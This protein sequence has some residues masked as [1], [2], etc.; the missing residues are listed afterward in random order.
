V[1]CRERWCVAHRNCC[2]L[3]MEFVE[4][5]AE[6]VVRCRRYGVAQKSWNVLQTDASVLHTKFAVLHTRV[7]A[8]CRQ[9]LLCCAQRCCFLRTEF[10][11]CYT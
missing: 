6:V 11:V 7:V 1:R 2:V 5:H 8:Y 3:Q 9:K 4:L 10:L